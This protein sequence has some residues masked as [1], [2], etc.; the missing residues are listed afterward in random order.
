[1][2]KDKPALSQLQ[3]LYLS[4]LDFNGGLA[5][6]SNYQSSASRLW[7]ITEKAIGSFAVCSPPFRESWTWGCFAFNATQFP[8]HLNHV[9]R[10]KQSQ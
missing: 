5:A 6:M 9:G 8:P 10:T 7:G 3:G 4:H 2:S 1:M